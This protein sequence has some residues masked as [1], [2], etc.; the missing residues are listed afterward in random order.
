[1]LDAEFADRI[2][3]WPAITEE[4]LRRAFARTAEHN[5]Q[6]AITAHPRLDV[7]LTLM[8]WHLADRWGRVTLDGIHLSVPLTHRL[9]GQLVNAE[10]PSVTRT[11]ARLARAGLIT[12]HA[13]GLRLRGT[14]EQHLAILADRDSL[15]EITSQKVA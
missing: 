14:L 5:V 6:H 10:R 11:L 3:L 8:L 15:E 12:G 13:S 1:V 7:R 9:L 2:R 4:L